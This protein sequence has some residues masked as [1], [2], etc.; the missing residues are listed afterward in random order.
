MIAAEKYLLEHGGWVPAK[1]LASICQCEDR[2]FR[3]DDSPIRAFVISGNN[4]YR[5]IAHATQEEMDH[6][7][8]RLITHSKSQLAHQA[9][10]RARWEAKRTQQLDFTGEIQNT[11]ANDNQ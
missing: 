6:Y 5:H 9:E 7:C 4:G 8:A 3:G 2:L 11:T 1:Q 10:I